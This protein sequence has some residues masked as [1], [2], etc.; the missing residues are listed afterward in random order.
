MIFY[1]IP[2]LLLSIL[3]FLE[4]DKKHYAFIKNK[5]FYS[6]VFTFLF[7]FIGFR[8]Q[9]GCDWNEYIDHF[10]FI[11]LINWRTL[12]QDKDN[13]FMEIGYTALSKLISY[14]FNFNFLILIVSILFAVPLFYFCL[15]LKRT[16]LS[17]LI[18]YPYFFIVVG[19][20]ALRQSAAIG[21]VM[22]SII[23]IL[24]NKS[25]FAYLF[26][27]IA[28]LFHSSG[29]LFISLAFLNLGKIQK[30]KYK[31]ILV[32]IFSLG[33]ALSIIHNF[34]SVYLKL[35]YYLQNTKNAS[36]A[37]FVWFLNFSPMILYFFNISKFNFDKNLKNICNFFFCFEILLLPFIFISNVIAYRF[38][39][40]CF[41]ISICIVSY[42]PEAQIL[43]VKSK[44]IIYTIIF[45]SFFS[46]LF[47][48]KFA[49]HS[50]CWLPY[51][52]YFLN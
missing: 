24:K 45:L 16:Y 6:I 13:Q 47:W 30:R 35:T 49:K 40:Y 4:D 29:I 37:I 44:Y 38:S 28:S 51:Q 50:Y 11:S 15:N 7:F 9:V 2:L 34:D 25:N 1:L 33:I 17:L 36:S 20:G 8:V 42:L 14:K 22:L 3:S 43:K 31:V 52:N 19:M 21:F 27:I 32:F 5:Y 18:S 41:P 26:S 12:I 48:I 39:L 10:N 23:L 46:L